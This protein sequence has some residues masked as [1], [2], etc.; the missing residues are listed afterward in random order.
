[1]DTL[2]VGD[3]VKML[4]ESEISFLSPDLL[5]YHKD[6]FGII[7]EVD[8]KGKKYLIDFNHPF[9][10]DVYNHGKWFTEWDKCEGIMNDKIKIFIPEIH[11]ENI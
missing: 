4:V 6:D 10:K 9:N 2:K 7:L 11:K 1:M 8:T 5:Y 3:T